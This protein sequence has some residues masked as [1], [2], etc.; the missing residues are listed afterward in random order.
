[1]AGSFPE[2][3]RTWLD[4]WGPP[5]RHR[6]SK[7]LAQAW[8]DTFQQSF[9]TR[10][11]GGPLLVGTDCSGI[12]AP[13]HALRGLQ[14][15]HRHC[16]SS[17]CDDKVRKMLSANTPPVGQV[18]LDVKDQIPASPAWNKVQG[19]RSKV[20]TTKVQG[21]RSNPNTPDYVHLY[22]SGFSCKPFSSLHNKSQLLDEP[23]A[24][25]FWAVV[26]RLRCIKPPA[27]LLENVRGITRCLPQVLAALESNGLYIV[28]SL[29]M[30]PSQ[31]GEPLQRPR[32]YFFGVRQDV[33]R[34]TPAELQQ[35]LQMTWRIMTG[36]P[37]GQ[38]GQAMVP[39]EKRLL[40]ADHPDVREHQRLRRERWLQALGFLDV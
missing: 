40:P 13:I 32:I 2:H 26:N 3:L 18:F 17:E 27:F 7:A 38:G 29:H 5:L 37:R 31:L 30:D 23:Q 16:W 15:S 1:M 10:E 12:E 11:F 22:V 20:Q 21:P 36:S 25:I 24:Q 6:F 39:L 4:N 19:P 34:G 14:I 8:Q 33:A 35:V 28:S 9:H